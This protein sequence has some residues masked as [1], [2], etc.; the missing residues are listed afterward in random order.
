MLFKIGT[1]SFMAT[2]VV[3][4]GLYFTEKADEPV[5]IRETVE[6][7]S[8]SVETSA[9]IV[10][11][12]IVYRTDKAG[13]RVVVKEVSSHPELSKVELDMM[14]KVVDK[15]KVNYSRNLK[16]E[17]PLLFERINLDEEN[18]KKFM[19]LIGERRMALYMRLDKDATEEEKEA[20]NAFKEE[21]LS[22]VDD[23]ITSL[24]GEQATTYF[25]YREKSQ[26]YRSIAGINKGLVQAGFEMDA[27]Q[28][29]QL[30]QVMF[31]N[32]RELSDEH[33]KF[34]WNAL[35]KSPE[36][37]GEMVDFH[38]ERYENMKSQASFLDDDQRLAFE[39]HL[40]RNLK[41]YTRY[42]EHAQKGDSRRR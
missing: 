10:E 4:A 30:A 25:G 27:D 33:S 7:K 16:R 1:F 12:K 13:T 42:A 14:V 11:E 31:D 21:A 5:V 39:K 38:K 28:Q 19:K 20:H 26:Q 15:M 32:R 23:K 36:K 35:R 6:V 29:D 17:H 3:F 8:T 34:D 24:I 9:P 18:E 22:G 41:Q 37:V 2:S 40:D